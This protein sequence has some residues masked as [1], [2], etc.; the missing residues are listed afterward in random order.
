MGFRWAKSTQGNTNCQKNIF[1]DDQVPGHH[2]R[3]LSSN[4]WTGWT[5]IKRNWLLERKDGRLRFL[6]ECKRRNLLPN[7]LIRSIQT[8]RFFQFASDR[9]KR[10]QHAYGMSVL[11][12]IIRK[13][14]TERA[15]ALSRVTEAHQ[16]MWDFNK[17]DYLYVKRLKDNLL[18]DERKESLTR[19][20]RKLSA[21]PSTQIYWSYTENE[22]NSTTEFNEQEKRRVTII[23]ADLTEQERKVLSLGPKFVPTSHRLSK[24]E[25]RELESQ[26][27]K[28]ANSLRNRVNALNRRTNDEE[29]EVASTADQPTDNPKSVMADPKIRKLAVSARQVQQANPLLAEEE[30]RIAALK[31]VVMRSYKTHS[32]DHANLSKEEMTALKT[33]KDKDIVVKCSDKSKSLVVM[34]SST[35]HSKA[36]NILSDEDNYEQSDMTPELLEKRVADSVKKLKNLK[37]ALP[38]NV[39]SGLFPKDTRFPEFYGLPK[40]HKPDAPLRPVV[41][42]FAGALSPV[43]ILV[44]R[45]LNQLLDY[46][47]AHLK[48]TNEARK[49]LHD[50]FPDLKTPDNVMFV[51]MDVVALYPSIPIAD[52]GRVTQAFVTS[53]GHRY[54]RSIT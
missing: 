22:R 8:D 3:A 10:N 41:A 52:G 28:M 54:A 26:I 16:R 9:T 21:L 32:P 44:E 4:F 35:Y 36:M 12:D 24:V 2:P 30:R 19:L 43:S 1:E 6:Q 48:N 47:P 27:D 40:T 11:N 7:F 14:F 49:I 29:P 37:R 46:V 13:E 25:T 20:N 42:A 34:K 17:A 39:Y 45:V 38:E 23:D 51:T 5:W 15:E 18:R 53:R 33:L 50:V 31:N